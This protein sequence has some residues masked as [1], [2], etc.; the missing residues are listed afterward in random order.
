M[1]AGPKMAYPKWVWSPAGGWCAPHTSPRRCYRDVAPQPTPELRAA[2]PA[3]KPGIQRGRDGL[4]CAFPTP[5]APAARPQVLQP[6]E[7]EAQ[8][9]DRR[10]RLGSCLVL[11]LQPV[12]L[13]REAALP[14]VP[15][16]SVA[17]LVQARQAG[18]PELLLSC[19]WALGSSRALFLRPRVEASRRA[20]PPL[21][22]VA[23]MAVR[24]G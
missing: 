22:P 10:G 16:N 17:V 4:R 21:A 7:L 14:A 20:R 6:A 11:R 12:G 3:A 8:H 23:C 13:A 24:R 19:V 18:R 1:G 5:D 15:T 9:G 2:S